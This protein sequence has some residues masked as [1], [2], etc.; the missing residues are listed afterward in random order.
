[1][2]RTMATS[3]LAGM[4]GIIAV[5]AGLAPEAAT[6]EP[7]ATARPACLAVETGIGGK[8]CIE[9]GSGR[10]VWFKDCA[11]CPEMVVVPGA[12][13]PGPARDAAG[14]PAPLPE[15]PATIRRPFAVGRLAITFAQWDACV[16]AR[17]CAGYSPPDQGW[18]RES[19]PV[20]N[21]NW[22][23]AQGYVGWLAARTGKTYRLPTAAEREYVTRAGTTT[24]FWWGSDIDLDRANYDVP[25]PA[26]RGGGN[27]AETWKRVRHQTMPA[28]AFSANPWGLFNVHGNVWEW[29]T[30]CRRE[31]A[32]ADLPPNPRAC[33]RRISCGGSW[34]D[35]A[36]AARAGGSI[37]FA[38]D[39]R[40]PQQG[41][42]VVRDLP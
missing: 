21:V 15:P 33:E 41:F 14:A 27:Q 32:E 30:D 23:D 42:R 31:P 7:E 35:F 16:A 28:D 18:G 9:P 36:E 39:S 26:R 4:A 38:A 5:I 17:G 40:S 12:Q 29:T 25:V 8:R 20:V 1:M 34:N 3:L 19:R 10:R 6:R 2:S 11:D 13:R 22:M 37:G 24:P